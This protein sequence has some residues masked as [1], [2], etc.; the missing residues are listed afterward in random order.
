MTDRTDKPLSA[1]I[2]LG[3]SKV[4]CLLASGPGAVRDEVRIATTTPGNVSRKCVMTVWM[5]RVIASRTASAPVSSCIHVGS[6]EC[7]TS[8]WP[9]TTMPFS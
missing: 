4:V 9:R 1:G 5:C 8:V 6:C 3:G 7:H 2:E